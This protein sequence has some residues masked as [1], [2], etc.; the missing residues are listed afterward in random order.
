MFGEPAL[1]LAVGQFG[2]AGLHFARHAGQARRRQAAGWHAGLVQGLLHFRRQALVRRGAR[3]GD[4]S[5]DRRQARPPG[6][7]HRTDCG[8]RPR[9]ATML[10]MSAA[11]PPTTAVA[12]LGLGLDAGGTQT[13]WALAGADGGLRGEGHAASISGL[14][15]DSAAGRDAVGAVL[16]DIAAAIAPLGGA[17]RVVAGITGFEATQAPLL[18]RLAAAA[19]GLA[20]A[21]VQ[22]MTDIEL[23]CHTAFAPGEGVVLY[24]GT[25]SFAAFVDAQGRMH[26]AG[27][28]GA[29]IDDAGGGHWIARRAL[30]HIWRAE[31]A[32][33]GAWQRSPLARQVFAHIGGSDWSQTR[34]W[35]YSG[36]GAAR[37][38]MGRLALAVAAAA[39]M[40]QDPAALALL[41]A[42]GTELARLALAMR[43]RFG[44]LPLA[45]AGRVFE[46][47]P[48]IELSLRQAL[49]PGT[50]VRRLS[51]PAHQAA[52]RMAARAT[53]P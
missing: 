10:A 6:S 44:A 46:L 11:P 41:Q 15:L 48:A 29:V 19:L 22:A 42:A 45:L 14:Q 7:G 43:Q 24:A 38:E 8:G 21:A 3:R 18:C 40:Q 36:P 5:E 33:P 12:A 23:V 35:V 49:P 51:A 28:R 16:R 4:G 34:G 26:R 31:D 47:H 52:A 32:E 20:P 39:T 53:T 37:G 13:R 50:D 17:G 27:G 25:G 30:R 1:H 9:P 2:G